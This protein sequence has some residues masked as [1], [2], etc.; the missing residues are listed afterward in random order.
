MASI[1][2]DWFHS[3]SSSN[4][5]ELLSVRKLVFESNK[6][7]YVAFNWSGGRRD[8]PLMYKFAGSVG[9]QPSTM[10]TKIRAMIRF[11]F[12]KDTPN[13]P[14]VWTTLGSL[15]N[16]LFSIG[17][18]DAAKSIYQLIL[19]VS[20][21]FFSFNNSPQQYSLNPFNG[22]MP[23]KFLFN[24]LDSNNSIS[25][26]ELAVLIDGSTD[27]TGLNSSY[28]KSDLLNS[29]LFIESNGY[30][31][32]S[33]LFSAFISQLKAFS[34]PS[35]L[36]DDDWESIRDNPL[37]EIS[38]FSGAVRNI[39]EDLMESK[40]LNR[41]EVSIQQTL[42]LVELISEQEEININEVDVL[43][44]EIRF[45]KQTVRVRDTIWSKRIKRHYNNKCVISNCDVEGNIFVESAHI[46]PDHLADEDPPHR[47]NTLNG[48]CL[49]N[50]CHIL[51]DKGYISLSD[52]C[53][54]LVSRSIEK[55]TE[56]SLKRVIMSSENNVI[57]AR[58]DNRLPLIDFVRYH[59][60]NIF[61]S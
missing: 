15:W 47:T 27:R 19:T 12:L 53:V 49:C 42:P 60:S 30:L 48:I 43:S 31:V 33:G 39:L 6:P 23:L 50:H 13:C 41:P 14:L 11:G 26:S 24:V 9:I 61:K 4:L 35:I 38:P 36:D 8:N 56:Q 54:L 34:P 32:Y 29:G 22:V 18:F 52:N 16:D 58:N 20:L 1:N 10:Q 46:K 40:N 25:L 59:R 21:S 28:W 7:E 51:F 37:I 44:T 3:R 5:K 17:N 45:V 55:I 57:K 2:G